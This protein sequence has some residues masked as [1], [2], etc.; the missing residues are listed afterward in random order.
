MLVTP[1]KDHFVIPTVYKM[2]FME[3]EWIEYIIDF[4]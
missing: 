1:G 2:V 3:S 4:V